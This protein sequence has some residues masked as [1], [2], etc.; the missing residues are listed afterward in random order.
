MRLYVVRHAQSADNQYVVENA[1][2]GVR[3]HGLDQSYVNRQADPELSETGQK[4]IESLGRFLS[5]KRAG[6]S[7]KATRIDPFQDSFD[8]THIY[9]SLMVRTMATAGAVAD[10]LHLTPAIWLDAHEMGG[11]WEP[12]GQ[13]KPVGSPG[14]NRAYFQNRFPHFALPDQLGEEG[15]WNRPVETAADCKHRAGRFFRE[16]MERH[17]GTQDRVAVVSHGL[18]YS[19]MLNAFLNIPSGSR[20][21]FAMNNA[22]MT[23][24]DFVEDS[25][26]VIYQNRSDY[27]PPELTT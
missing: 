26:R 24:I 13:G 3:S 23:R 7:E 22:A 16:L 9:A 15:W 8:F 18:F 11:I 19:F 1:H 20:I 25:I 21:S 12:D 27:F 10:A 4:Q 2:K 5:Q 14:K 6:A 17:G